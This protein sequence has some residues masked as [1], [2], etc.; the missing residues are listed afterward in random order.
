MRDLLTIEVELPEIEEGQDLLSEAIT[1]PGIFDAQLYIFET[2][3]IL[4]SLLYKIPGQAAALLLS[5]VKPLLEDLS[6]SLQAVKGAGDVVSVLKII[7]RRSLKDISC[8]L[9][10]FLLRSRRRSWYVWR[11]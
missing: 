8:R 2:A 6:A 10:R 1:N 5:I 3:G 7:L 9:W 4:V 11:L